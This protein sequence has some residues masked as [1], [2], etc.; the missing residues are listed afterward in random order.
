MNLHRLANPNRFMRVSRRIVPVAAVAAAALLGWGLYLGLAVAPPDYQQG[1][2]VRI[3]FVH[4]PSAWMAMLTYAV[5]AACGA[6]LLVWKHPLAEVAQRAAAPIGASF[7]FIC[8]VTGSLWGKPTWGTWWVWDARLTSML[9]LF[10]FYAGHMALSHAFDDEQRGA[11]AA[12]VLALV[13][14]VNLPIIKFSVDWWYTLHQPESILR[15]GGP[16]IHSSLLTPLFVMALG[17]LCYFIAVFLLRIEVGLAGRRLET[18]TR[19][20][21]RPY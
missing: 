11:R 14:V 17:F 12:A 21:G 3:M 4:V 19:L 18:Q 2:S 7:T 15:A 10:F 9:V 8:L 5:L 6:A 20:I 16:T 1:D 13:G